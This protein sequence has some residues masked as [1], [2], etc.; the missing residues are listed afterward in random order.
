MKQGS[1]VSK[2][3]S[4]V[5]RILEIQKELQSTLKICQIGRSHLFL[6]KR[7]FTTAS[8]GILANY[9]KRQVVQGLLHYLQTIKTLQRTD[10][11]LQELLSE[12]DYPS[13]I[14]LLLECQNAAATY[15]HFT[16]V[17]ALSGKLQD[18]LEMAEEQ[19][20]QALSQRER[21]VKVSGWTYG[22]S[23]ARQSPYCTDNLWRV[24]LVNVSE[25]EFHR[26]LFNA[27]IPALSWEVA[28]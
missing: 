14:R 6:A 19:L 24:A 25:W 27:I 18:T 10:E 12:G 22:A 13:A 26:G 1:E 8:L 28:C 20:D 17:A 5:F 23:H 11:R 2:V 15:K 7:Q 4:E 3:S 9:R 21:N 16:C